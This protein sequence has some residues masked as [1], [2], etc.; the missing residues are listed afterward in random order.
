MNRKEKA[1]LKAAF[2][3]PAPLGKEKFLRNLPWPMASLWEFVCTQAR[4]I[5]KRVW[6]GS[7]GIMLAVWAGL[8][9]C[10]PSLAFIWFCS[11][12]LPFLGML[13]MAEIARSLSPGMTDL[14]LSCK[15]NLPQ[16][17]LVRMGI[18]GTENLLICL[19]ITC[20]LSSWCEFSF[21]RMGVYLVLPFLLTCCLSLLILNLRPAADCAYLCGGI[22][23][24]VSLLC[25]V[26][27]SLCPL[28]FSERMLSL[29]WLVFWCVVGALCFQVRKLM[30]KTEELQWNLSINM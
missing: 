26:S 5:R 23:G 8:A 22:S 9:V 18:L 3:P 13:S 27:F 25:V 17:L 28:L 30:R 1:L 6:A 21:L 19:V 15:H 29:W 12:L 16:L 24:V 4:F 11:A 2:A 10:E 7:A 20:W 14:H